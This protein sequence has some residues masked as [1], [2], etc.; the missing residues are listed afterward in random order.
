MYEDVQ[1][2]HSK[3]CDMSTEGIVKL[4]EDENIKASPGVSSYCAV[5]E[6][7]FQKTGVRPMTGVSGT[8]ISVTDGFFQEHSPS[9]Y[10]FIVGFDHHKYPQL[11]K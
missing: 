4:M 9:L 8:F 6:L 2:W 1:A 5:S 11:E 7:I 3:L 10:S